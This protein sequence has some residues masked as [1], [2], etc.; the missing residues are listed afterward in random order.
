M[1]RFSCALLLSGLVFL[2]PGAS[3]AVSDIGTAAFEADVVDFYP[4]QNR[5]EARG[6]ASFSYQDFTLRADEF[7]AD[8]VT[9]EVEASGDLELSQA[10]RRL[11]GESLQYNIHTENGVLTNAWVEEQGVFIR[12]EKVVF[13]PSE[14]VAHDAY[15]T[16]CDR[17]QP[18]YSFGA[19]AISLTAEQ[20]Q[21]GGP[22]QS[23]RLTLDRARVTY[24]G[25]SLFTLPRY[26]VSVGQ[27]GEPGATPLPVTGFSRDDGPYLSIGYT[28]GEA[29][30]QTSADLSYRYTTFRGIRGHL[31]FLRSVGPVEL[32]AGYIR[33]EDPSDR[34]FSP[35]DL[36]ASLANVIINRAPE[37]GVRLPDLAVGRS[38]RLRAEW[39]RGSYSERLPGEE[40]TWTH[41]DRS[42][43]SVLLSV[44]RYRPS[45][46]LALSHA[47]G[48]RR[49][50]Y[51]SG[52]RATTRLY[53]HSA[54]LDLSRK[55]QLSLTHVT[56]RGSG[57]TPFLFDERGPGRELLSD[58]A[59]QLDPRWRLRFSNLYDL[60]ERETRDTL[61]EVTRTAH[62]L[63]YTL[64]WRKSRGRIYV[65]IGLAPPRTV[66]RHP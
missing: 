31:R 41:A 29:G 11:R 25:R 52:D 51:S 3:G 32:V 34:E 66:E 26:S 43:G 53:R 55:V 60:E 50:T 24:R 42:A 40:E 45:R 57:E 15:F 16:T 64:G 10:G 21:A 28:L 12:G 59:W 39:L 47:F 33:R 8:P 62:C 37:Y 2:G 5:T 44:P 63:A 23:G 14:V 61:F 1:R 18:H 58:L 22:P 9:G 19:H 48:W 35:D 49:A 36:E 20:A 30:G 6:N 56:R 46:N 17:P 27:L 38:M 54:H 65:G 4:D 7:V 13:S